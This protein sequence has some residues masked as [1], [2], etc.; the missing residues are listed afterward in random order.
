M[1]DSGNH[2]VQLFHPNG[3]FAGKFGSS[4]SA[5]GEFKSGPSYVAYS[6]QGDRI[7]VSD[8]GNHRVQLFHANGTFAGKFGSSGSATG[9]S[10]VARLTS[11]TPPRATA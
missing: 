10:S 5:D 1:A 6:P 7:A 3:T 11:P 2:R 4:G 9:S 8:H